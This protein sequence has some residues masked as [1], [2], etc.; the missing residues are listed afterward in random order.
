MSHCLCRYWDEANKVIAFEVVNRE[1]TRIHSNHE[2]EVATS[3]MP[4]KE[5][6]FWISTLFGYIVNYPGYGSSS[7]F[8]VGRVFSFGMEAVVDHCDSNGVLAEAFCDRNVFRVVL[9]AIFESAAM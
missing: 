4:S 6:L 8:D 7:V 5:N 9:R 3:R 1:P 2:C